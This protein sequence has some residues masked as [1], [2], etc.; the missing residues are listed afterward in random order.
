MARHA[1]ELT[2]QLPELLL[3]SPDKEAA[4]RSWMADKDLSHW[5][6]QSDGGTAAQG[7]QFETASLNRSRGAAVMEPWEIGSA[8]L[9]GGIDALLAEGMPQAVG[10]ESLEA[11]LLAAGLSLGLWA[12]RHRQ[13]LQS[14]NAQDRLVLLHQGLSAVG[15]GALT[16]VGLSLVLS[17]ALAMISGGQVWL[18]G[19]SRFLPASRRD[20]FDLS[21]YAGRLATAG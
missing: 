6:P 3:R 5:I 15:L 13:Q 2:G 1:A 20:P 16:G 14:A 17:V 7:W 10:I 21:A 12:L 11:A 9:D 18:A 8:H 19:L 4:L